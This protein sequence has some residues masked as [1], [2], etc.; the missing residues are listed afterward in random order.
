M[1][2]YG[3]GL[4]GLDVKPRRKVGYSRRNRYRANPSRWLF[5][6]ILAMVTLLIFIAAGI[7]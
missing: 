3:T 4:I 7:R 5:P 6:A 1:S 2:H